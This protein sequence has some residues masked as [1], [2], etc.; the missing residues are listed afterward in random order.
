MLNDQL[1]YLKSL[2]YGRAVLYVMA[3]NI[4]SIKGVT[5]AGFQLYRTLTDWI[6]F[7]LVVVQRVH[8]GGSTRWRV[9]LR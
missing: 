4:A 7:G 1:R 8:E 2:G 5:A 9:F 6:L 3:E